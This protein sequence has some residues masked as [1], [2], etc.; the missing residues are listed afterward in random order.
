VYRVQLL[1]SP[2]GEAPQKKKKNKKKTRQLDAQSPS[3][4]DQLYPKAGLPVSLAA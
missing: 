3:R 4:N 2:T 1:F